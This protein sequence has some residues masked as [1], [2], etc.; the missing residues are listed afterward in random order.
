MI[1]PFCY[2]VT[3]LSGEE[4]GEGVGGLLSELLTHNMDSLEQKLSQLTEVTAESLGLPDHADDQLYQQNSR[5][6]SRY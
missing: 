2:Y 1:T 4:P 5:Y 3:Q 6:G